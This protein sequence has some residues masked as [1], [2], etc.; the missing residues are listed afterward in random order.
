MQEYQLRM[1]CIIVEPGIVSLPDKCAL[2]PH[3]HTHVHIDVSFSYRSLF[4]N[5]GVTLN[6]QTTRGDCIKV[7]VTLFLYLSS[8]LTLSDAVTMGFTCCSAILLERKSAL[9][10]LRM[11]KR[12]IRFW[13]RIYG[14]RSALKAKLYWQ[15]DPIIQHEDVI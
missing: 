9:T 11:V 10:T 14:V 4:S 6:W 15:P 13:G 8:F 3:T 12:K 2:P 7:S 5:T 1:I